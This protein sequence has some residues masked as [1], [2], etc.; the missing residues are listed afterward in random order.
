MSLREAWGVHSCVQV[1]D[2]MPRCLVKTPVNAILVRTQRT[3][4]VSSAGQE[5]GGRVEL[6]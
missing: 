1:N 3:T 5:T 2:K 6:S 4:R